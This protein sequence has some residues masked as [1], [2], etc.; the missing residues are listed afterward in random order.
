MSNQPE[1]IH[2]VEPMPLESG[3]M[4]WPCSVSQSAMNSSQVV[5][6]STPHSAKA[7]LR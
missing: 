4:P 2:G 5:G 6:T 7:D 1:A 3:T